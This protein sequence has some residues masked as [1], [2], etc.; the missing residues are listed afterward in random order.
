[1]LVSIWKTS[2]N[3]TSGSS[4]FRSVFM[5]IGVVISFSASYAL[6]SFMTL[7]SI[8]NTS[9]KIISGSSVF[10]RSVMFIGVVIFVYP[11]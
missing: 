10:M 11:S 9:M 2:M 1:M 5:S 6:N 4:V 7:T 3:I 8:W